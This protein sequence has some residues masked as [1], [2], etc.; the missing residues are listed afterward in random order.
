MFG[1][2][3]LHEPY[4]AILSE[5][6]TFWLCFDNCHPR[7]TFFFPAE[8]VFLLLFLLPFSYSPP[9]TTPPLNTN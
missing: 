3:V 9:H 6:L 1:L 8:D 4:L 2:D 5:S 7:L